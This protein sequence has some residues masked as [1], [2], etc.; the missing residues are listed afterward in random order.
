MALPDMTYIPK[1]TDIDVKKATELGLPPFWRL[2]LDKGVWEGSTF[3]LLDATGKY[4]FLF[5]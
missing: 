4:S 2:D 5:Y 3:Q 1:N